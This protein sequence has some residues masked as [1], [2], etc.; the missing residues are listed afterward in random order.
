MVL[1]ARNTYRDKGGQRSARVVRDACP[2]CESQQ[3]KKNGPIHNGKQN[4]QGKKCGRQ[5]VRHAEDRVIVEEQRTLVE[6]LLCEKISLHGICR[7]VGVSIRWLMDFMVARFEGLPDH[8]HIQPVASPGDVQG[9][10]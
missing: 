6:R 7:T 9:A 2:E 3:F 10:S 4:H 1:W 5:F 8:L